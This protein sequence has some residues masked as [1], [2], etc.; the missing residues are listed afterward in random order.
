MIT[1]ERAGVKRTHAVPSIEQL[2]EQLEAI[3]PPEICPNSRQFAAAMLRHMQNAARTPPVPAAGPR[4]PGVGPPLMRQ[5]SP[6]AEPPLVQRAMAAPSQ[7]SVQETPAIIPSGAPPAA[8]ARSLPGKAYTY[9]K[10][11]GERLLR[12]PAAESLVV[13]RLELCRY[14]NVACPQ[15]MNWAQYDSS[16]DRWFCE[17]CGWTVGR[18]AAIAAGAPHCPYWEK[19]ETGEFCKQCGCGHGPDAE[20]NTK[21]TMRKAECPRGIWPEE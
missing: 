13:K 12:G 3:C 17:Q 8:P 16:G 4:P 21:A 5:P 9:A 19:T 11:K 10:A 6:S 20:L 15:C 18:M 14:G 2:T 7:P 1:Y